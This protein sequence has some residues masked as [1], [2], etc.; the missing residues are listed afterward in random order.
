MDAIAPAVTVTA[1]MLVAFALALVQRRYWSA[2][3]FGGTAGSTHRHPGFANAADQPVNAKTDRH[4]RDRIYTG[5]TIT[6]PTA[7]NA[8]NDE[9]IA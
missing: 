5:E 9:V 6:H 2:E 1:A 3:L 7:Q 4:D 8:M